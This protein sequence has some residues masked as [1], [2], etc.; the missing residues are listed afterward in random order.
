MSTELLI[1]KEDIFFI[2]FKAFCWHYYGKLQY[3]N[4]PVLYLIIESAEVF[5]RYK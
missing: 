4:N 3:C 5:Q 2:C 1:E